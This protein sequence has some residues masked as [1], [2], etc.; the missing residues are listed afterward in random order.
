MTHQN[1]GYLW[2]MGPWFWAVHQL[3]IPTW[4]G[5]RLWMGTLLLVAGLGVR[6]CARQLGLSESGAVVAGLGYA[7][8]PYIVDYIG[9]TSAILLPWAGLGWLV[10]LTVLAARRGGWRHP[11][12]MALVVFTVGGVNATSVLLA[13][14]PPGLWLVYAAATGEVTWRRAGA[15]AL[16]VGALSAVV[17]A[18]WVAGLYVEAAHG[19]DILRTTETVPTV[20]RT[21]SAAEVLRGLGYWYFY[22]QDKVQPWTE[23]G[24]AYTQALWLVA[25]SFAVPAVSLL[26]GGLV[27]WRYRAYAVALVLAGVVVAVGV[28][29]YGHSSALAALGSGPGSSIGLALRSADREVPGVVLGLMLL[30]GAGVTA[31]RIRWRRAGLA[32]AAVAVALLA[33]DLPPLWQ[34][35][36]VATN[37]AAPSSVPGYWHQAAAYLNGGSGQ[38]RVLGLPGEDFAAY[39]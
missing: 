10:G 24:V 12:L 35:R 5:Q 19:L 37:L 27:R 28:Y 31:L 1:I 16:R 6:F 20:A 9:R 2:P 22:G 39:G 18:W 8:S 7:L 3:G 17:S 38:S 21:S 26:V 36:L 33:A 25:V 11:A 30:L 14:I 34:G 32:V 23:A 13:A 15:V 29:P 4:V